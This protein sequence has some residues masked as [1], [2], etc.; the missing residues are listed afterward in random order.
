MVWVVKMVGLVAVVAVR[1][2][3]VLDAFAL[4]ILLL[5][6]AAQLGHQ[7]GDEALRKETITGFSEPSVCP[8]LPHK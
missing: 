2:D 6:D 4:Q 3:R 1:D 8:F 7:L 5:V